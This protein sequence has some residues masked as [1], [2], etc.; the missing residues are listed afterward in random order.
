MYKK[1]IVL[2]LS[3]ILV[4]LTILLESL[5]SSNLTSKSQQLI[6]FPVSST[7]EIRT[8]QNNR[9]H[10]RMK[11]ETPRYIRLSKTAAFKFNDVSVIAPANT[12]L[13]IVALNNDIVHLKLIE[14]GIVFEHRFSDS[15]FFIQTQNFGI[16]PEPF[17]LGLL[18]KLNG[19]VTVQALQGNHRLKLN[20]PLE[21]I[22]HYLAQSQQIQFNEA[23]IDAAWATFSYN[24]VAEKLSKQYFTKPLPLATVYT[25][26]LDSYLQQKTV[27]DLSYKGSLTYSTIPFL[28]KF[29]YNPVKRNLVT[30]NMLSQSLESARE[31]YLI[32]QVDKAE[33]QMTDFNTRL[34]QL[35]SDDKKASVPIVSQWLQLYGSVGDDSI[36]AP[37]KT[38]M[39]KSGALVLSATQL[40]Q[41]WVYAIESQSTWQYA[42]TYFEYYK[43]EIAKT[44]KPST[45]FILKERL[46]SQLH[47]Y[48]GKNTL[49]AYEVL[50][51]LDQKLYKVTISKADIVNAL[52]IERVS[53]IRHLLDLETANKL[54]G[55]AL[56][57]PLTLL[58]Q[59][60]ELY[61]SES[62]LGTTFEE[63][64]SQ[65]LPQVVDRLQRVQQ[66]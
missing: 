50:N 36:Y 33:A 65:E 19:V 66:N 20:L 12:V 9:W 63:Y 26:N 46:L 44:D 49:A 14:G 45:L 17:S 32:N 61:V 29:I 62:S 28:E 25:F 21:Q 35:I 22:D 13:K 24:T 52:V 34:N 51:T 2:A 55:E 3:L 38:A 59:Q 16:A 40:N 6:E 11:G 41:L 42:N 58:L 1:I 27:L 8:D 5:P 60:L 15:P 43:S 7:F 31:L 57:E 37:I 53:Q 10:E 64:L 54:T 56:A 18:T 47:N 23:D 30:I 48:P 39:I 4:G